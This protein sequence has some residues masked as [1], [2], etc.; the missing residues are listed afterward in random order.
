MGREDVAYGQDGVLGLAPTWPQA[1]SYVPSAW[2]EPFDWQG[3]APLNTPMEE[4]VIYEMHVR[5]FTQD[6]SSKVSNPGTYAGMVERL[7]YLQKLGIN[8]VELLPVQEFNELEYYAPIPGSDEFRFNFW[9][10]STVGFFAPMSRFS[11]AAAAGK[12]GD[13]IRNEFKML[14]RECH[15]RG[16]EVI[17]DVVFN[18]TAE[19]NELGP[20]LSFRGLDNRVYYMLAPGGEYYNYS[21][22]GNT[23]NCN[24]P[25]VQKFIV[26]CLKYWVTEFHVDGFR[27][28]LASILTRAPS[29]W[30][31]DGH[32]NDDVEAE[33]EAEQLTIDESFEGDPAVA[34]K[35]SGPITAEGN[36]MTDGAG[37]VTGT[38][39]T[40]PDVIKAISEDPVLA[41]TKLIAEAWDCDG[42][43]QVGAFP[44]YGGRWGE[45]NGKFRDTVRNFIKG[46]DG[47]FAGD[48]AS[49]LCGSP[50]IYAKHEAGLDDWWGNNGGRQWR[51]NRG[52]TASVNFI[53][54][55]DGFTLGDLVSYNEKHN[56]ANGEG[57]RDG[58]QHNGSWNCGEE[59]PTTSWDVRRLRQRQMRNFTAA[60]LLSAG[61]PMMHMGDEYGHSKGG[62]NNTYCH[63]SELNYL[64]WGQANEDAVG[65]ARF[66]SRM[67][68][69]RRRHPQLTRSSYV[70]D[71]E[72]QW[73]GLEPYQP[74]WSETSRLVAFTLRHP[75]E[76]GLYVAFNTSHK[77]RVV[78]LPKWEGRVWM[79]M[80][81]TSRLSPYDCLVAD[82]AL[83]EAEVQA[84]RSAQ[85]MWTASGQA[86]L[87]PWSCVVMESVRE[88]DAGVKI[89]KAAR[90]T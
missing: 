24:A 83:S 81:D 67:I 47:N 27:F 16:I 36:L 50:N 32:P 88:D 53:I 52:P 5:G 29:A 1:A 55:H 35:P 40:E 8:A 39:L 33:A 44:H 89:I 82:E 64:D 87:L 51:G 78:I 66:T 34:I 80:I 10:Y 59:G 9:G 19:G 23:L 31:P 37:V 13:A 76:G 12:D 22:C 62:N 11:A 3:D 48:F 74:D 49:C 45:W 58:E 60:L 73:H 68:Q 90:A 38:P 79:P 20:T 77:P 70:K 86:P 18:H 21:G 71:G 43:N 84:A 2:V 30:H 28:D 56:M 7:D 69:L 46:S 72:V 85:A 15:K 61:V 54:A 25:A 26:D 17:L 57:N 4:L 65:L 41:N 42:L 63:D 75:T 14:V 6:P